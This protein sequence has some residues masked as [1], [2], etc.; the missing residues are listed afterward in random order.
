MNYDEA[1]KALDHLKWNVDT[2]QIHSI[3]GEYMLINDVCPEYCDMAIKALESA[4]K[5]HEL[6]GL[7]KRLYETPCQES[8]IVKRIEE[9]ERMD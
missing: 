6:L 9:L 8:E 7:Y 3:T 2:N 4:K 5:E 1:I